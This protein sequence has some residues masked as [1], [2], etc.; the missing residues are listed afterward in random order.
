L[1]D[2]DGHDSCR[3]D[4][5]DTSGTSVFENLADPDEEA[6]ELNCMTPNEIQKLVSGVLGILDHAETEKRTPKTQG[7][8]C[9]KSVLH[10]TPHM[11]YNNHPHPTYRPTS[12]AAS[13]VLDNENQAYNVEHNVPTA[14]PNPPES[15]KP[16]K[17]KCSL[18]S[19]EVANLSKHMKLGHATLQLKIPTMKCLIFSKEVPELA[20]H[21]KHSHADQKIMKTKCPICSK[22]FRYLSYH[23]KMNHSVVPETI[24]TGKFPDQKQ[25]PISSAASGILDNDNHTSSSNELLEHNEPTTAPPNSTKS[26]KPAIHKCSLCS[27]KVANLSLHMKW[28]HSTLQPKI[29]K[30]ECPICSKKFL[31]LTKH[32]KRSHAD[33]KIMKTKCPICS[34]EFLYLHYHMKLTHGETPGKI[35]IGKSPDQNQELGSPAAS[36]ILDNENHDSSSNEFLEHNETTA[37]ASPKSKKPA[38]HKCSV[39]SKKVAILSQHMKWCHATLQLKIPTTKCPICSK[40]VMLL[41]EHMKRRHAKQNITKTK[42]PICSEKFLYLP[43]HMKMNHGETKERIPR[44]RRSICSKRVQHLSTHVRYSHPPNTTG[45]IHETALTSSLDIRP[46]E[47]NVIETMV[48][49][50]LTNPNP[51]PGKIAIGKSPVQNQELGLPAVSGVLD[52]ENRDSSSS[53]SQTHNELIAPPNPPKSKIRILGLQKACPVCSVRI[54]KKNLPRHLKI[55]HKNENVTFQVQNHT[56]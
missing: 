25:E 1:E 15:K 37:T 19:K 44:R 13:G 53:Q 20:R 43:Q 2:H 45:K 34:K 9:W 56:T 11:R 39:C 4:V 16:P 7:L 29:P 17:H 21:M 36:G 8:I 18:C 24:A 38:K 51:E 26:K 23:M 30:I 12:Q 35:A 40:E 28:C 5:N 27:K 3:L 48:E 22:E 32:M 10:H 31:Q 33:Q 55:V 49:E 42:C 54:T 52:N 14:P 46:L 41:T 47:N 50:N 6:I